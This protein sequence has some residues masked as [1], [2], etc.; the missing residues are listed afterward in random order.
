MRGFLGTMSLSEH[1][2]FKN[3][4]GGEADQLAIY[5]R[6]GSVELRTTKNSSS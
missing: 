1:N 2:S 5:K 6:G 3:P 4:T